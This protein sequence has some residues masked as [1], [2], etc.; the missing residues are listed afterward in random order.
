MRFMI[1]SHWYIWLEG[2]ED[3]ETGLRAIGGMKRYN[4]MAHAFRNHK[5]GL[6]DDVIAIH[7]GLW[8]FL[9]S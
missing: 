8:K 2:V 6:D 1:S 7:A 5:T 4:S 9:L 3:K